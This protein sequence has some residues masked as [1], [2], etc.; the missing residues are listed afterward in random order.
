[1]VSLNIIWH[2]IAPDES[3]MVANSSSPC[4][5]G[6]QPPKNISKSHRFVEAFLSFLASC[7]NGCALGSSIALGPIANMAK[8]PNQ[9]HIGKW[10]TSANGRI[11]TDINGDEKTDYSRWRLVDNDGRLT[12]C[13]LESDE[14]NKKWPQTI[15]DKHHLGL[16]TVSKI[17]AVVC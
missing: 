6:N 14:E 8:G 11:S 10:R 2:V 12:W 16:P 5:T 9:D 17:L 7:S 3:A 1:L 13:Y 15:Y 4:S